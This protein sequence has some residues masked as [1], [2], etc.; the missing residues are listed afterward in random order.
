[1]LLSGQ[2]WPELRPRIDRNFMEPAEEDGLDQAI[3]VRGT[4]VGRLFGK[5]D[6]STY[7]NKLVTYL[8]AVHL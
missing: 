3:D 4:P 7:N 1:M 6:Y 2:M 5:V 8:H